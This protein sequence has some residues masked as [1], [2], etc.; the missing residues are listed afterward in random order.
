VLVFSAVKVF[1]IHNDFIDLNNNRKTDTEYSVKKEPVYSFSTTKQN[2]LL[3]VLDR[4]ISGYIPQIFN[5]K[6][7][8]QDVF[9]GFT[10]FPNCVSF[11]GFTMFGMPSVYGG[12]EYTP[13]EINK[14]SSTPL[15]KKIN[16]ALLLMPKLFEKEGYSIT[17]S[18]IPFE[19]RT[20]NAELY[21]R[22]S[23]NKHINFE[24]IIG[25]YTGDWL[26][27][28]PDV[29]LISIS[30]ALKNRLIRFSFFTIA[31]PVI[32]SYVYDHGKYLTTTY[33]TEE[34]SKISDGSLTI[35]TINNYSSLDYLP[36]LTAIDNKNLDNNF[37]MLYNELTHEPAFFQT[38]NY[39][40]QNIVANMN[41]S[42]FTQ[43]MHYHA[44]I[45]AMMLLGEWFKL[46]KENNV[47]DNTRII[48]VSDHGIAL[49]PELLKFP[50]LPHNESIESYNPVLLF[51][52]FNAT[53]EIY[54]DNTF[55]T[56]ADTVFLATSG[57]IENPVN[58]FTG[59]V[60]KPEK[61]NGIDLTTDMMLPHLE[62]HT[63]YQF[64]INP[65]S[66]MHI[67]DD[68]FKPENWSKIGSP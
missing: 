40:P 43:E 35:K 4:A 12:Y 22:F 1:R 5:E 2:L 36:D 3:I 29:H 58:P 23:E 34:K 21:N 11:S 44:N 59:Q 18:D 26:R 50:P 31:P 64:R 39:T 57:I 41:S 27:N 16:D 7:E 37:I 19:N 33:L 68:I 53:G 9:S 54:T 15:T 65:K 60:L 17:I 47:Y 25:K 13:Q 45:A 28:H 49:P 10:W 24:N 8:L 20:H 38:P 51:K 62:H 46:L 63:Q 55:M 66:W 6:P 48:I 61:T 32:R 52:D 14:Q 30:K 56:N 42:P 67:H